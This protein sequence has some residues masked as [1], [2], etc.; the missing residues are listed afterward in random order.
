MNHYMS[1]DFTPAQVDSKEAQYEYEL[2]GAR[3]I[4]MLDT[5]LANDKM[6]C[7]W[8]FLTPHGIRHLISRGG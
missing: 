4:H 3:V 7:V 5:L 1:D 2:L 6:R 8:E